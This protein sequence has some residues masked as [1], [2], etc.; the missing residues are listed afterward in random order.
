MRGKRIEAKV[1]K[2][3]QHLERVDAMLVVR[4]P[5]SAYAAEAY[6]GL[7]KH[8]QFASQ[9]QRIYLSTLISLLDDI[10]AG[11]T[12][13]TVNLRIRD[14][15]LESGVREVS[16]PDLLPEAFD[17]VDTTREARPAWVLVPAEGRVNVI[18]PGAR[19]AL[20]PSVEH[21]GVSPSIQDDI[22]GAGALQTDL[23]SEH[24]EVVAHEDSERKGE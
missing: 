16:N 9:Q 19:H 21:D 15:L 17:E 8:V 24:P 14:R 18:R 7:R 20:P 22:Q 12:L 3:A 4:E 2:V 10:A 23:E 6:E 1:D 11:A 13:E 5:G